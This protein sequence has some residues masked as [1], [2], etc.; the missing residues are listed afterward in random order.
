MKQSEGKMLE[1]LY[2]TRFDAAAQKEKDLIWRVLCQEFFCQYVKA[3]DTV[4]DI[5]AGYGEFINHIQCAE[6]IAVDLNP[7]V[8]NRVAKNVRVINES[9]TEIRS[10]PDESV[11]VVFMSNFL[12]H[13][14]SKELVLNTL[15]ESFR[16]LRGGGE[17][18]SCNPISVF[19]LENT[20]ITLTTIRH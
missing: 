12:E 10:L 6:K 13:L 5:G 7:D 2:Q 11:D 3:S 19:S 4:V 17:L 14:P 8:V 1:T 18:L 9:C 20:G 16:I 15:R